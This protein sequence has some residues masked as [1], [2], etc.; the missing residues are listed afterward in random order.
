MCVNTVHELWRFLLGIEKSDLLVHEPSPIGTF[1]YSRSQ[2]FEIADLFLEKGIGIDLESFGDLS[3]IHNPDIAL[4]S[5]H[6]TD[7]VNVKTGQDGK[8]L[9]GVTQLVSK[10]TNIV[11]YRPANVHIR[12]SDKF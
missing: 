7:I 9:L 5:L 4:S 8:L 2:E 11:S 1:S 6:R 12:N 3:D 10:N